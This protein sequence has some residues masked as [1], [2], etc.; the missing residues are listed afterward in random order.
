MEKRQPF[1]MATFLKNTYCNMQNLWSY[2][3]LCI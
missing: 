3:S 1:D 2:I